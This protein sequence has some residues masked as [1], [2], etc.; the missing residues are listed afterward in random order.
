MVDGHY[1]AGS[2]SWIGNRLPIPFTRDFG[3]LTIAHTLDHLY[4][5]S[6]RS[7]GGISYATLVR[8][9]AVRRFAYLGG[10]DIVSDH[11]ICPIAGKP[12]NVFLAY[13]IDLTG[14]PAYTST[15]E[16]QF[17][18]KFGKWF[19]RGVSFYGEYYTG[20]HIFSEY[21][22]QRLRTFG[23]GFTVDFF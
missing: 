20:R 22:D 10:C 15:H 4:G 13:H 6:L 3:E 12:A 2:N 7:Y 18:V 21:F 9:T 11:L 17:G 19:E 5:I 14:T 23:A 1:L 16:I 8:P